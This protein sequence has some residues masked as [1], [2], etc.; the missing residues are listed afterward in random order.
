MIKFKQATLSLFMSLPPLNYWF[1]HGPRRLT[2]CQDAY[3][4]DGLCD[5]LLATSKT[6]VGVNVDH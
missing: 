1:E 4:R 3:R 2:V 5:Y 6:H